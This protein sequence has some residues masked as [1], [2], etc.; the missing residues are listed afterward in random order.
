MADD[1]DFNDALEDI[2][3]SENSQCKERYEEGYRAG[4][5][6]GNPEGYHLGYH[7]GAEIGREIGIIYFLE[8][9]FFSDFCFGN[10]LLSRINA[11]FFYFFK[12]TISGS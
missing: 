2:F 3:L 7:R 8:F 11:Y 12:D 9:I 4:C 5:D 10:F 1:I 6:A